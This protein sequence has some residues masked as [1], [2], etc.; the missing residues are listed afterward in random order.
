MKKLSLTPT[1]SLFLLAA[2]FL[3]A[4]ALAHDD[5]GKPQFGGIVAEGGVFQLELVLQARRVALHISDHGKPLEVKGGTARLTLLAGDRKSEVA[6]VPSGTHFEASGDFP[7][8]AGTKAV[9]VVTL[10]G[11]KA[12]TARFAVK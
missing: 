8:A 12:V 3:P 1:P 6:L 5:H 11:Q 9:A 4:A 10:P 7:A 2:L